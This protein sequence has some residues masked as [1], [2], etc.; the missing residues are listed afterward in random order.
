MNGYSHHCTGFDLGDGFGSER[1]LS[2]LPH[3]DVSSQLCSTTLIDNVCINFNLSNDRSILLTGAGSCAVPRNGGV[4]W[5]FIRN[6]A[7]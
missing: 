2:I 3:I 4:D 7:I 5:V 6:N 1:I